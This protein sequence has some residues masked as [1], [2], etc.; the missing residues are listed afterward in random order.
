ME[1]VNVGRGS[2]VKAESGTTWEFGS[3]LKYVVV[4]SVE[5]LLELL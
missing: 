3:E 5:L 1:G 2:G 4:C